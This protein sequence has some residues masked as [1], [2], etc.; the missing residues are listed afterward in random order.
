MQRS[1]LEVSEVKMQY[2]A[3]QVSE[4]KCKIKYSATTYISHKNVQAETG[5]K[6]Y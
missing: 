1:S 5:K 2:S 3:L 6:K 4:C